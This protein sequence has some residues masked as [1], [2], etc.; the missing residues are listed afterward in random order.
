LSKKLTKEEK[1]EKAQKKLKKDLNME[2]R[3]ALFKIDDLGFGG[4]KFKV[5]KNA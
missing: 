5:Q 2:C 4:H 3:V 1:A